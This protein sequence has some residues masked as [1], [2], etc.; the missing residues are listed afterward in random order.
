MKAELQAPKFSS[1][2]AN[3]RSAAVV[4]IPV[5]SEESMGIAVDNAGP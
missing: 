1:V 4:A 5:E 3:F 2:T